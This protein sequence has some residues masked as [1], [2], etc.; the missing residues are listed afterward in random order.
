[1]VIKTIFNDEILRQAYFSDVAQI[2]C[3][4]LL[5]WVVLLFLKN[6]NYE[7]YKYGS[8]IDLVIFFILTIIDLIWKFL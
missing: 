4:C 3:L 1:M 5:I 8:I 2:F 7:V 6:K